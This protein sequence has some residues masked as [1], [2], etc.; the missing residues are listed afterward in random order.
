MAAGGWE[1]RGPTGSGATSAWLGGFRVGTAV[2]GRLRE[3]S[4]S[5]SGIF[6]GCFNQSSEPSEERFGAMFDF[7]TGRHDDILLEE[8]WTHAWVEARSMHAPQEFIIR[9]TH[10]G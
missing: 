2:P 7:K 1:N 5:F 4:G 8:G 9:R 3:L 6:S 10:D